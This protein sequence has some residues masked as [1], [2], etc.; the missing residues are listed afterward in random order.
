MASSGEGTDDGPAAS[1]APL[2]DPLTRLG[3]GVVAC[4]GRSQSVNN[5]ESGVSPRRGVDFWARVVL[6]AV[7]AVAPLWM[8]GTE[9]TGGVDAPARVTANC[10]G[11]STGVSPP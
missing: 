11:T 9:R 3:E 1:K 4:S 7:V 5:D 10:A 2:R 6:A 8:A